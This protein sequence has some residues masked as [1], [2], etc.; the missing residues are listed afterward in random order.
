MQRLL[1]YLW[2]QNTKRYLIYLPGLLSF[3]D[4]T[5]TRTYTGFGQLTEITGPGGSLSFAYR[6]DGL[7]YSK[8]TGSGNAAITHIHLWDG[9][10]IVAEAGVSGVIN[11]RYIRGVG[12]VAREMDSALQY[13]QFNAH[14][15]VLHRIDAN[16]NVL[17]NYRYDAFGNELDAEPLD[18]NPFRYCGE[19]FDRETGTYY[20]RA[21]NYDPF[22]GRFTTEDPAKKDL[23]FFVY[24][25]NNP[26]LYTDPTGNAAYDGVRYPVSGNKPDRL[27]SYWPIMDDPAAYKNYKGY[28]GGFAAFGRDLQKLGG[29]IGESITSGFDKSAQ[30]LEALFNSASISGG[31]G[32][33]VGFG[34]DVGQ[35]GGSALAKGD[36]WGGRLSRGQKV[37]LSTQELSAG[38]SFGDLSSTVSISSEKEANWE[39]PNDL[40]G[41]FVDAGWQNTSG[42]ANSYGFG[43][44]LYAG[45]GFNFHADIDLDYLKERVKE[46][47]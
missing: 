18:V 7:R 12:L 40:L 26:V 11:T 35:L 9:Q 4:G 34:I 36:F 47:W 44:D 14:G 29:K 15:D 5:E 1:F 24:A 46:I 20:L 45:V 2:T 33:G 13:Y 16:G 41:W 23:N 17:K 22:T 6:P 43:F 31:F 37:P 32:L 19:Y 3:V 27:P 21:R 39:F 38:F 25:K 8:T 28:K 30:T 42:V 10:N